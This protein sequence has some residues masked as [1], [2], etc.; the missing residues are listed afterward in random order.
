MRPLDTIG[1]STLY[2]YLTGDPWTA[3]PLFARSVAVLEASE[4]VP[5]GS[6]TCQV[7]WPTYTAADGTVRPM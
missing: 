2:E 3:C 6:T 7:E 1:A 4:D 5:E